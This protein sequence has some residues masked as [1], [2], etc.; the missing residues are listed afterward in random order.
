[1]S[2]VTSTASGSTWRTAAFDSAT[3]ASKWLV[4]SAEGIS[5]TD[6]VLDS[7]RVYVTGQGYNGA[8]TPALAYFLTVVAYDRNAVVAHGQEASRRHQCC[9]S[10]DE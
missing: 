4:T 7:G 9:R 2:Q 8:S 1:M 5:T 3:G 10:P 6:L